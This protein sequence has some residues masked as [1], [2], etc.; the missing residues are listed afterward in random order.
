MLREF[1]IS[2]AMH[3]LGI[4]TTR[5]LAVVATGRSVQRETP[6]PGAVLTRVA[7]S[8]LRVGS[9][10]LARTTNDLD[11]LRRLAD[12]AIERHHPEAS[13]PQRYVALYRAVVRAQA[14]LV[15]GWMGVGFV[16]GVMNTD[17]MTISGE[18]IDY[19]PCA[20]IDGYHP[21]AV[22]SSIDHEG[23]Y[24]L[25]NQPAIAQWNL[26]RFAEAILPLL[27]EDEESAIKVA[28]EALQGFPED[29]AQSWG[30]CSP[31]SSASQA[32]RQ[33][34]PSRSAPSS[35]NGWRRHVPTSPPR[36]GAWAQLLAAMSNPSASSCWT[37][38]A[39]TRGSL[40]GAARTPTPERSSAPTRSTCRATT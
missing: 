38:P 8:H 26:A 30:R 28:T 34:G 16:H 37:C 18:T 36:S 27:A 23:R 35:S 5:S 17:N 39:S 12:L 13:G 1:L 20:F 21:T 15:A 10:Q 7:S 40:R 22:F 3:A 24:A 4:P 14:D 9:F 11:L 32:T 31:P 29:Y 6:M 19:G 25:G 33:H 2:E